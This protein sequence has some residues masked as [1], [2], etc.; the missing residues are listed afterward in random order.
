MNDDRFEKDFWKWA[1]TYPEDYNPLGG[2]QWALRWLKANTPRTLGYGN[3]FN[4]GRSLMLASAIDVI[5]QREESWGGLGIGA[6]DEESI[7]IMKELKNIKRK[8][9]E[10]DEQ[11]IREEGL[12]GIR[13]NITSKLKPSK[14]KLS[15]SDI[16]EKKE[17]LEEH[18]EHCDLCQFLGYG[19]K[20]KNEVR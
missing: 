12:A 11:R 18:D 13:A 4:R 1:K 20:V 17:T 3:G 6:Q 14:F 8:L 10:A 9:R 16:D 19:K 15:V 5:E 2:A 7:L